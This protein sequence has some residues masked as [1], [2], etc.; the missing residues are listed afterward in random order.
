MA[1]RD[2]TTP[3]TKHIA[4]KYHHIKELVRSNIV[5]LQKV[6]THS[7]VADCLAKVV[8]LAKIHRLVQGC[9]MDQH[10]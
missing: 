3:R 5:H 2:D 8:T 4:L 6:D 10:M 7:Q 9:R 1:S